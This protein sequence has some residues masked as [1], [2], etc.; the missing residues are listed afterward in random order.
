MKKRFSFAL[1]LALLFFSFSNLAHA[2]NIKFIRLMWFENPENEITIGF[3]YHKNTE[4]KIVYSLDSMDIVK[5]ANINILKVNIFTK[6]KKINSGFAELT[7]L[8]AG[9]KYYFQIQGKNSKTKVFWFKTAP[10]NTAPIKIVSG[11]DS[12]TNREPR[13]DANITIKKIRPD[14]IIFGGDYTSSSSSKQWKRWLNDWQLIIGDDGYIA[15]LIPT[16]GNHEPT[17][18]VEK[19]FNAPKNVYYKTSIG[20]NYI[21]IYNLNTEIDIEGKQT[22]WLKTKLEQENAMWILAQYHKPIRPHRA[23]KREGVKQYQYWAPLFYKYK[24]D[25]ISE[26]D[27]H[28][29]KITYPIV[30]SDSEDSDEGFIRDDINGT[31]FIGEG[32]WGAPLREVD[33]TK[34]WT[35]TSG[36]FN[37]IK[38]ITIDNEKIVVKTIFTERMKYLDIF[39]YQ[40]I[41]GK[42]EIVIPNRD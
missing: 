21:S 16:Q 40:E 28:V 24:F 1:F 27:S 7:R 9:T 34:S 20:S 33:D 32:G 41:N 5:N 23:S 3:S 15:P 4:F 22:H 6:Y 35:R 26:C 14:C 38:L 19:I 37:Q 2:Q 42:S 39:R 11:G 30:P 8:Q 12:R 10:R 18:A 29:S 17:E 25:L 31:V 36:S 13:Q